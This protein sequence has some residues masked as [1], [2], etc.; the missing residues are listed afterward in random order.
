MALVAA[1]VANDGTLMRPHLVLESTGK[2]GTTT[3]NSAI[4]ERVVAPGVASEITEAMQLAVQGQIGQ[5]FTAGA[6]VPGLERGRQVRHGGARPRDIA[7]FLVHRLR[8]GRQP[9]G[10]DRGARRALGRRHGQGIADRGRAPAGVARWA[11]T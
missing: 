9:A 4:E 5:V 6:N 7:A 1:T 11:G 10:R 8:A 2:S 3:I